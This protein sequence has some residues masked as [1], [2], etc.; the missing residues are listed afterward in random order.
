M[1][2]G[3]TIFVKELYKDGMIILRDSMEPIVL[4]HLADTYF[5]FRFRPIHP[6]IFHVSMVVA[7][8]NQCIGIVLNVF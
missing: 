2:P 5:I 7:V 4:T 8:R 1:W 3:F 6:D